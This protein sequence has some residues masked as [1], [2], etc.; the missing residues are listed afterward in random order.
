MKSQMNVQTGFC[1]F[2]CDHQ[3]D[4]AAPENTQQCYLTRCREPCD[5]LKKKKKNEGWGWVLWWWL[6]H[7][8][9]KQ[10][11]GAVVYLLKWQAVL[12]KIEVLHLEKP[13]CGVWSKALNVKETGTIHIPQVPSLTLQKTHTPVNHQERVCLGRCTPIPSRKSPL[14]QNEYNSKR[15]HCAAGESRLDGVGYKDS[16]KN[17]NVCLAI[18]RGE[19]SSEHAES[20]WNW[21]HSLQKQRCTQRSQMTCMITYFFV[22]DFEGTLHKVLELLLRLGHR[23]TLTNEDIKSSGLMDTFN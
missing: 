15:T 3:T 16:A 4:V 23:F 8:L 21:M 13:C 12:E 17:N 14:T 1:F 11:A 5:N 19:K 22:W 20:L 9:Q 7:A 10:C 2:S 18:Y 6:I